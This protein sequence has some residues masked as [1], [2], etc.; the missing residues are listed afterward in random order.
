M[1][2]GDCYEGGYDTSGCIL[3]PPRG[4]GLVIL[5]DKGFYQP[6]IALIGSTISLRACGAKPPEFELK[7]P[8]TPT[9]DRHLQRYLLS[10]ELHF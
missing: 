2:S 1:S 7:P 3:F 6:L 4:L 9:P 5:V 8:E 10:F